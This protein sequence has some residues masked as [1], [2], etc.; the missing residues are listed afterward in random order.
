M[1]RSISAALALLLI[2]DLAR[3]VSA[4]SGT[5]LPPPDQAGF[6][7][8]VVVMMENRSFD[9]FYGW[10]AGANG[11][12][13][14]SSYKDSGGVSHPTHALAPDYQGCGFDDPGHSY[15]QGRVQY[16]NGACDGFLLNGSG[17]DVYAIGYYLQNDLPFL[18]AAGPAFTVLDNYFCGIMAETYPNRFYMHA[19][20]TDRLTNTTVTSSLPTIWDRLAE[21]GLSGRYYFNDD[22]VALRSA[23]AHD[24]R[25]DCEESGRGFE[26]R[27]AQCGDANV[28][29]ADGSVRQ[30]LFAAGFAGNACAR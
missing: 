5:P 6:D 7:H 20:Q 3:D 27:H 2:V 4:Q 1:F 29:R 19:A 23:A 28:Q 17:N 11:Q 18:G 12:Q 30:E 21:R 9:H 25:R 14:G 24:S 26:F 15:T 10:M 13:A 8:V 22:R 16:D